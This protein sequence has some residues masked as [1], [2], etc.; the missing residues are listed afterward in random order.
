[1]MSLCACDSM[2]PVSCTRAAIVRG[3][4]QGSQVSRRALLGHALPCQPQCRPSADILCRPQGRAHA[5]MSLPVLSTSST[6]RSRLRAI[7]HRKHAQVC[8]S[9]CFPLQAHTDGLPSACPP[10]ARAG[11]P[12]GVRVPFMCAP[13]CLCFCLP[14]ASSHR[15]LLASPLTCRVFDVTH[16]PLAAPICLEGEGRCYSPGGD[17]CNVCN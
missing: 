15:P 16:M 4:V 1:M 7:V 14:T 6:H 2:N 11:V 8:P 3:A 9:V 17:Q 12:P 10:Q 5:G 13:V